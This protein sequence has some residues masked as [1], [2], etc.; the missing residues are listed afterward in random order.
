MLN[1]NSK[2]YLFLVIVL[3]V[4]I[5]LGYVFG[6]GAKDQAYQLGLE[7]GREEIEEKYQTKIEEIFPSMPESEEIFSVSGKIEEI[8]DKNL[9]LEETIYS[10]NPFE[11]EKTR[12]WQIVI[13]DATEL[14]KEV[15]KT[16]EEMAIEE[17]TM[18]EDPMAEPPMPFKEV[19]IEFSELKIGQEIFAE[20][21]ENIKGKTAFEA[22][23]IILS[24][25]P[26]MPEEPELPPELP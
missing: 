26:E 2:T 13:T 12:Q 8:K 3:I 15:E 6:S 22:Q 7:K 5:A 24:S 1:I 20:A 10:A 16:P 23:K 17:R 21:G 19:K 4:G 11:E 9:A 25:V 14:I 18:M